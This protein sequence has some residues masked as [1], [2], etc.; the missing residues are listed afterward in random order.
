MAKRDSEERDVGVAA[1]PGRRAFVAAAA[2]A[3]GAAGASMLACDSKEAP[4]PAA[5]QAPAAPTHWKVQTVWDAGTDGWTAF[6]R[7]C[8]SV[9]ETTAGAVEIEPL[10]AGKVTASFEMLDAVSSGKL[11][12]MN[13]F[14]Q[15]WAAKMPVAAFLASYPLGL[16]RPDQWETWF[17]ALGGLDIARRAFAE[18]GVHYVGPV[19][20]DLNLIHSR[21]PIRSFDD[22]K[23]KKIRFPGGMIAD[24]FAQAGVDTV[25]LP[26][27]DV[28]PALQKQTIDAADFVGPAVNFALGFADVAKYIIMGPPATPCLHQPVDLLDV[29]VNKARW[30]ALPKHLQEIVEA[31]TRQFSWNHY[32]YIQKQN[33]TAW[34]RYHEKGVQ[35]IRLSDADVDRLRKIAIPTWFKWAKKDPLAREAF[36]SQLAFMK[37]VNVG[38]ASDAA[39][40][41]ATGQ[42][43][44][45]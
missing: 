11:D 14:T 41:D 9:K 12:G 27:G 35:V 21:V 28:Y 16:D 22:F 18:H 20:H 44:S 39:L 40:V 45:L 17:Y 43:L 34:D 38:Y 5:E 30:D 15:Y 10:P 24:V 42:K 8:A 4:R 32:A 26:G 23:G 29:S 7:F 1:V 6:Q 36:A 25:I 19:Q 2:A 31:T 13:C 33:I 37:S 3:A